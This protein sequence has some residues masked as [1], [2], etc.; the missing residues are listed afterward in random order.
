[1]AIVNLNMGNF[2]VEV[3]TLKNKLVT[4]EKEAVLHEELDKEIFFQKGIS[5]MWKIG[6]RTWQRLSRRLK[7]SLKNCRMKMRNSRVAHH[8]YNHK[9][10]NYRI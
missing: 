7:C 1:M 3:N 6:K 9:M 8:Y 2:I 4:W 10:K 5:I